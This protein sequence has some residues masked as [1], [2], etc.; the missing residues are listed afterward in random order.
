[1]RRR[2][3]PTSPACARTRTS[4]TRRCPTGWRPLVVPQLKTI[5][6]GG[7]G[8]RPGHRVH[9]VPQR[10]AAR[11]GTRNRRTDRKRR[12]HH[13]NTGRRT[14]RTVL[15]F[16]QFLR[17]P[18]LFDAIED[19]TRTRQEVRRLAPRA[20]R[21]VEETR[22]NDGSHRHRARVR[23]DRRRLSRRGGLHR[24]RELPHTRP[25]K[26]TRKAR[27]AI[28][29]TRTSSTGRSSIRHSPSPRRIA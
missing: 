26:P 5:T 28:T 12:D 6:L 25:R 4:S 18:W 17:H 7:C 29:P 21:F 10:P 1:M 24:F 22:R 23:R 3:Q 15:R 8:D 27:S 19:R 20:L 11:V 2:A 14:R 13:R 9:L 16:P